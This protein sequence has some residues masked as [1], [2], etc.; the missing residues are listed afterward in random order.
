MEATAI[1]DDCQAF[2]AGVFEPVNVVVPPLQT[3]RLPEI[4]GKLFTLIT[5][6]FE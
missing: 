6:V 2:I 5:N 3:D 4:V 1:F